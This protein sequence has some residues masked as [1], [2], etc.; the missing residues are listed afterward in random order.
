MRQEILHDTTPPLPVTVAE[1]CAAMPNV[2]RI[3]FKSRSP[4]QTLEQWAASE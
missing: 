4:L 3:G 2:F 1:M